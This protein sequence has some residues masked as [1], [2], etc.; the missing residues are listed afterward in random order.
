M[1]KKSNIKHPYPNVIFVDVDGT[2]LLKSGL[3]AGLA[4][5]CRKNT[6]KSELVLWSARGQKYAK[7]FAQHFE[8]T[9]IFKTI[10]SKPGYIIDDL[11][12]TWIKYTK[13]LELN[14]FLDGA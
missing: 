4:D 5:W 1:M 2:L 6:E 13:V 10:I 14:S 3:N 8:I 11:G 12:W 9:D 7:N